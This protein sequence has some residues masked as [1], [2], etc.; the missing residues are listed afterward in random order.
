MPITFNVL[1]E[2][3]VNLEGRHDEIMLK[4]AM[5]LAFYGCFR[6]GELCL[7]DTVKFNPAVHLTCGDVTFHHESKYLT[8]CLKSSKTDRLNVGVPVHVG[9]S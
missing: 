7:A 5:S 8:L 2:I 4:C 6:A 3:F 9:C 1:K